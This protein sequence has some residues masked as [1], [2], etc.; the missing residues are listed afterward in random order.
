MPC[1]WGMSAPWRT[2]PRGI[3]SSSHPPTAVQSRRASSSSLSDWESQSARVRPSPQP[4]VEDCG[5]NLP[6]LAA[7]GTVA[8]HPAVPEVHRCRQHLAIDGD[9]VVVNGATVGVVTVIV[10]ALVVLSVDAM[11][12]LPAGADAVDERQQ[13]RELL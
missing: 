1:A 9:V 4:L 12:R 11:H 10:I 6:A 7:A 13:R 3:T 8:K 2:F 5:G